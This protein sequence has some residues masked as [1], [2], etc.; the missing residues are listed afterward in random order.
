MRRPYESASATDIKNRFGDYLQGVLTK[1]E[2]LLVQKHGKPVAVI[3]EYTEW[4]RKN[5]PPKES[6]SEKIEQFAQ[7]LK[8]RNPKMKKF[9]A[10]DL[11]NQIRESEDERL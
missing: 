10:V 6:W 2:P 4:K 9:S 7:S 1:H 5:I 3:L 11:V 8:K